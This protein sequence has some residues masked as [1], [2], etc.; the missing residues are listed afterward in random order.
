MITAYQ[1]DQ[2]DAIVQFDVLTGRALFDDAELRVIAQPAALHRQI[3]MRVERASSRRRV[4]QAL[5]LHVRPRCADPAAVQRPGRARQRP[6]HR[7]GYPY[8]DSAVP[9]RTR[10][11]DKAKALLAE[12][13]AA[14]LT[15]TLHAGSSRRSPTSPCSSRARRQR[16]GSPC[17][18]AVESLDTFYGAQWCPAEP[19][20]PPC[21]GAAELGIVDYGHRA[22]PTSTSTPRSRP[23]ASGTR[24]S[25]RRPSSTP[26]SRSSRRRSASTPR[27]RPARRSRPSS[28]RT[29]RSA[30]R[31]S[32]TT[33][34]ATRRSSPG[35]FS[36]ALGQMSF[37][38][39]LQGR[40]THDRVGAVAPA[41]RPADHRLRTA[42]G[43]DGTFHRAQAAA[44]ARHLWLL[45]TIV[46]IIANVL[47]TT[48]DGRSSGR[49]RPG[50]RRRAQRAARHG[51]PDA[52][53]VRRLDRGRVH[54]R[55][56]RLVLTGNPS[57][58]SSAAAIGRSASWPGSRSLITIPVGDR[59][60]PVRGA[61]RDRPADRAIVLLGVTIIVDPGVRDRHGPGRR[62]RRPAQAGCRSS[63]RHRRTR[64]SRPRS[65]TCSCRHW[66]WPSCTSATSRG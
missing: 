9:Q 38:P 25:T 31:T 50:E 30:C 55:L 8:F 39:G 49:S 58:R 59:G 65:A 43:A 36:S 33:S 28:T 11:I 32:T 34:P 44:V 51:P 37:S 61:T 41:R 42:R 62:R 40:L 12:A 6:C 57:C 56:R 27:R 21:S 66:R 1:G 16:P 48:S 26:P 17:N 18:V 24:R 10:D 54:A 4:R 22:T 45:A 60:R 13:G 23:R 14:N 20:D 47:P 7:Q 2:V 5:A 35:V 19:A 53:A 15:A 29:S 3:W 63:P 46:F 52:R 64:T